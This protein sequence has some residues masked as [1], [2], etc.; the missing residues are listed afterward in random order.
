MDFFIKSISLQD[1]EWVKHILTRFWEGPRVLRKNSIIDASNLP[2]FIA[3]NSSEN[4]GLVTYHIKDN[5][6]EIVTLNSLVENIGVGTALLN[7]VISLARLHKCRRVWL[8]T[9]NDNISAIRFYQTRGFVFAAI[10]L[11]AVERA[12]KLKPELP[13]YGEES[14]PIRDE[15]E[16]ELIL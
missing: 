1:N 13:L 4:I 5:Q 15:I 9:T 3:R 14:I 8:I 11:K 12:R 6:C 7:E 10:Y 2:G 16:F